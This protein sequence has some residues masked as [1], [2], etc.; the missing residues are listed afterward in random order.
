MQNNYKYTATEDIFYKLGKIVFFPVCIIL[1]ILA[2]LTISQFLSLPEC[3]VLKNYHIYCPGCGATRA[4]FYLVHF[5]ILKSFMLHP[6]VIYTFVVYISFMMR[7]FYHRHLS[8]KY[9]KKIRVERYLYFGVDLILIQWI[10][11]NY[12]YLKFGYTLCKRIIRW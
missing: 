9:H 12:L 11:K 1:I 6:F 2:H 8:Q 5:K 10:I 4:L 3:I 7:C